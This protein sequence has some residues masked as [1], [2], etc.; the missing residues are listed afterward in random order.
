MNKT[1]IK[2]FALW[3]ET[4]ETLTSGGLLLNT[5]DNAGQANTMTI[6]WLTGGVIWSQPI[7]VV[8]VRPSRF[9]YSRLDQLPEFTVNVLPS[10]LDTAVQQCGTVSGRDH[11][12]FAATGLTLT[13]AQQV[14][15]PV[16]DQAVIHYECRVVHH[17]DVVP[18]QLAEE[19]KASAYPRGDFHRVYF[20][21]VLAAYAATD[22]REQLR[23]LAL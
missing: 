7:L 16:I 19:I 14:R 8:F 9:T 6:G 3:S 20:G 1:P 17:N 21:E 11:D 23:R 2:L 22:A 12:K 10:T 18:A 13:P 15:V 5:A 4:M